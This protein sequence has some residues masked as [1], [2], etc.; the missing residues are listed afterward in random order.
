MLLICLMVLTVSIYPVSASSYTDSDGPNPHRFYALIPFSSKSVT[1]D[2][3]AFHSGA[4]AN[5]F[6]FA[7]GSGYTNDECPTRSPIVS[8]QVGWDYVSG[9]EP[10]PVVL[11]TAQV[12]EHY[13]NSSSYYAAST[14][15]A[16]KLDGST[17]RSLKVTFVADDF[18]IDSSKWY[19]LANNALLY[20]PSAAT[21]RVSFDV[22][23]YSLGSDSK[24]FTMH[25]G[26]TS[27]L[28][29]TSGPQSVKYYPSFTTL[30]KESGSLI[31]GG[32]SVA[33]LVLTL[34]FDNYPG[35]VGLGMLY[36]QSN[37]AV[38][39]FGVIE[40]TKEVIV[41]KEVV[42]VVPAEELD[43][44]SWLIP[45]IEAFFNLEFFPGISLGGIMSLLAVILF[46]VLFLKLFG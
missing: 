15:Y 43:L 14:N 5:F 12:T 8:T 13:T 10:V 20:L 3:Y 11:E 6:D 30:F 29:S 46:V 28:V 34:E 36:G 17:P 23:Y 26:S 39:D 19:A 9:V 32:Y 21:V 45:P 42:K 18:H 31:N 41:E 38:E 35:Q 27:N 22:T 16:F 25:H 40:T 24:S 33:R 7:L 37:Y 1:V 2:S 44:F 4:D